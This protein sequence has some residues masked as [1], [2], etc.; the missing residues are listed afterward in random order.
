MMKPLLTNPALTAGG[1][2][3]GQPAQALQRLSSHLELLHRLGA[4]LVCQALGPHHVGRHGRQQRL[5]LGGLRC[6]WQQGRLIR[7]CGCICLLRRSRACRYACRA[8]VAQATEH[9]LLHRWCSTT[10]SSMVHMPL[11]P[12]ARCH[13]T[14]DLA[15]CARSFPCS[16]MPA[17]QQHGAL[18]MKGRGSLQFSDKTYTSAACGL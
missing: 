15:A 9:L 13:I 16:C 7:V 17:G 8:A 5:Q 6:L 14:L 10:C 4:T 2:C 3:I 1:A 11:L 18:V 12:R